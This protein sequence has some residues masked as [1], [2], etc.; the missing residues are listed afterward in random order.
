MLGRKH[1]WA[2]VPSL[3]AAGQEPVSPGW[4][5][6]ERVTGWCGQGRATGANFLAPDRTPKAT[7][8][9]WAPAILR[10]VLSEAATSA[11]RCSSPDHDYC[12]RVRKR[13]SPNRAALSVGRK[14]SRRCC[15]RRDGSG[16]GS[17]YRRFSDLASHLLGDHLTGPAS[18]S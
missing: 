8:Q 13:L 3:G 18:A 15:A 5:G 4:Y 1:N 17:W 16:I 11:A 12:L 7:S 6:Q 9:Q 2:R 10:W 14:L